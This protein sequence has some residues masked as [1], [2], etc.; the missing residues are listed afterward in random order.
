MWSDVLCSAP[1][2]IWGS[3]LPAN[4]RL[5]PMEPGVLIPGEKIHLCTFHTRKFFKIL[6][7]IKIDVYAAEADP[8][9]NQVANPRIG[10]VEAFG[11]GS[12]ST[13][14]MKVVKGVAYGRLCSHV[15]RS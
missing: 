10:H 14:H 5:F 3:F 4:W 8:V 9:T 15:L 1:N 7:T 2:I 13:A 12:R 6:Q 11:P